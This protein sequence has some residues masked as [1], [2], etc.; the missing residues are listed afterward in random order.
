MQ[1]RS[2]LTWLCSVLIMIKKKENQK[3]SS[4][5]TSTKCDCQQFKTHC[6]L[7]H[8][9]PILYRLWYPIL[10]DWGQ[11]RLTTFPDYI[12]ERALN[13]TNVKQFSS[14]DNGFGPCCFVECL[15]SSWYVSWLEKGNSV[16]AELIVCFI[17]RLI[18]PLNQTRGDTF[19]WDIEGETE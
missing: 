7:E 16:K 6:V 17:H 19:S 13:V 15:L 10:L 11:S 5:F 2:I 9:C 12:E 1:K 4:F 3:S 8:P 18:L 14:E